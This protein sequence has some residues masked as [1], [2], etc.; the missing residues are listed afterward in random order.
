MFSLLSVLGKDLLILRAIIA[1]YIVKEASFG[2]FIFITMFLFAV[3]YTIRLATFYIKK[4][5]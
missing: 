2:D 1:M 5:K 3:E 4:I